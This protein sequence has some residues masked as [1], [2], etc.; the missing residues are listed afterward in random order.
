MTNLSRRKFLATAALSLAATPLHAYSTG[1]QVTLKLSADATGP[2]ISDDFLGLSYEVQQLADPTFFAASNLN[3]IRQFN[4]LAPHGVLR[5]GGNTSEFAWWKATPG[6][7]EPEH[8]Q[9]RAVEGEPEPKYYPITPEAVR[10]LADFLQA[11]E[12]SCIYGIGMGTNLPARAAE[13]AAFVAKTLGS[14]LLYFQIGNEAD[15]FSRHLRDPKTWSAK[16]YLEEWL[17]L[18]RAVSVRVPGSKFGMPDVASDIS[19]LTEIADAWASI[20]NPPQL[21][22]L[23]HHYYFGGP[24]TNPEVNV[25]NLLKQA[26]M[27]KVRKTANTASAAAEQLG[28]RVRMTEGN[29]CYRGGK[30]GVS[31]VF[32][33]ALWSADYSL[34]L[35][36]K[37]YSGVNLHGGTGKSVAN[38]VGGYLP[39]DILLE[40]RGDNPD[41]IATH[42]H[43]FY[44]PIATIGSEY[45]LEP[46][47]H[48]LK[49]AGAF[50]GGSFLQGDFTTQLQA[51]GV[52]AT[53]YA[54]KLPAGH[55]VIILNKDAKQKIDVSLDLGKPRSG[56]VEIETLHAPTLDSREA[57]ITRSPRADR[58]QDGKCT[59]TVQPST[60]VCLSLP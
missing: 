21:T 46:V 5:L 39:G 19:W 30:P 2:R 22:A 59:V 35:A 58:L 17:A 48:G 41:Q 27:D 36:Q 57:H 50:R 32:A 23:T 47:G 43:P 10:S 1:A 13:E 33:A 26:T 4:A 15:L 20:Q 7:S 12:W 18:A 3:L 53:A 14:R 56:V 6:S 44:T 54:A 24:A 11:T 29:T 28:V 55:I 16:I 49:F 9:I 8:P 34:L 42:P 52:N 51:T 25:D 31:D 45:V 40:K 60:G 37:N 38:S